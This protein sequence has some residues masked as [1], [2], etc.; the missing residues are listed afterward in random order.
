MKK[1]LPVLGLTAVLTPLFAQALTIPA[2][3]GVVV[4]T[5]VLTS[6]TSVVN[7]FCGIIPWI[8]WGLIV[9]SIVFVLVAA[10]RY[11]FSSGDPEKVRGA[12]KTLIY[13]AIAIVV[14]LIAAGVPSLINNFLGAGAVGSACW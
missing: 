10:Y 4:P 13:A 11:L 5:G 6:S 8:F 12:N 14:A 9:L 3:N 7:L 1:L 2:P